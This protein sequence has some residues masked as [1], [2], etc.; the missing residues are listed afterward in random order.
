MKLKIEKAF[1]D[2]YN[3]KRY[4]VGQEIEFEADRAKELLE[5][6]R[7]L[8]SATVPADEI[9]AVDEDGTETPLTELEPDLAGET[10]TVDSGETVAPPK[11]KRE[12]TK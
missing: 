7:H 12:K 6:D 1:T 4:K 8:V 11:K 3:A 10:V 5:D 2:K 9:V